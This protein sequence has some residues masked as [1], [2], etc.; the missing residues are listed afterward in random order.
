MNDLDISVLIRIFDALNQDIFLVRLRQLVWK[1][2]QAS[3]MNGDQ[4]GNHNLNK[5]VISI[6]EENGF[7]D[8]SINP[9]KVPMPYSIQ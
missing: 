2:L 3:N 8:V 4:F 5:A 7:K 6:L 1:Q 9:G